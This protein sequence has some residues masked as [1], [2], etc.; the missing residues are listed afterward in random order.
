MMHW[1][2]AILLELRQSG[3]AVVPRSTNWPIRAAGASK[4]RKSISYVDIMGPL[5]ELFFRIDA[6]VCIDKVLPP[7]GRS[8]S[9]MH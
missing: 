5:L 4:G 6:T 3:S 9:V 7:L 1:T 2:H 8:P